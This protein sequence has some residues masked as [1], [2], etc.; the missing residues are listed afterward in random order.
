MNPPQYN[1]G[2]LAFK[3]GKTQRAC[4]YPIFSENGYWWYQGYVFARDS[5]DEKFANV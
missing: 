3:H 2:F 4:P 5:K 1:E